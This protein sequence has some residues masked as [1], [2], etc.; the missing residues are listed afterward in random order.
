M[1]DDLATRRLLALLADWSFHFT[2]FPL[3]AC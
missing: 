3:H 2:T 1:T